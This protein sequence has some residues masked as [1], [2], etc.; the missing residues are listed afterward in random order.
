[1]A[2]DNGKVRHIITAPSAGVPVDMAPLATNARA[3]DRVLT[4]DEI[5]ALYRHEQRADALTT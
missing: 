4:S 2:S 1:M 3:Y 5:E